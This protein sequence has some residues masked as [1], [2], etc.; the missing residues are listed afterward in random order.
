MRT[1]TKLTLS[2]ALIIV[3]CI[4]VG[5]LFYFSGQKKTPEH[6]INLISNDIKQRD[7]ATFEKHF[8]ME[9][10]YGEA[11]DDVISPTLR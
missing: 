5:A 8:D 10:I 1:R 2:I 7:L 3:V 9:T 11:F 4:S 6:S